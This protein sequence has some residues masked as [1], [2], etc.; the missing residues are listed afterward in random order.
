MT[1]RELLNAILA[2]DGMPG[3]LDLAQRCGAVVAVYLGPQPTE[4]EGAAL[5]A[6]FGG[7][8]FAGADPSGLECPEA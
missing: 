8:I 2:R 7:C 5:G 3:L 1:R 6:W 4:L